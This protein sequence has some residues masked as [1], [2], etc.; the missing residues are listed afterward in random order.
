MPASITFHAHKA[1]GASA[2]THIA[3]DI[4]KDTHVIGTWLL[5]KED[6]T[7]LYFELHEI[8]PEEAGSDT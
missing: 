6:A 1:D 2:A 3:L 7:R 4:W 8:M 5:T